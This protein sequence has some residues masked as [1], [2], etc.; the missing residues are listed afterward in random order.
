MLKDQR[1]AEE[2]LRVSELRYRRLFE[3]AQD[4]ILILDAEAGEITDANPFLCELLGYAKT[5]LLGKQLWEIGVF[6]DIIDSK[7]AFQELQLHGYI[8][9]NDLPLQTKNGARIEV[10]FVSN[11]YVVGK[12]SVIQC[13]IRDITDRREIEQAARNRTV[14]LENLTV[15]Q[16]ETRKA[17]LN[18]MEDLEAAKGIIEVE[19]VKD[20]AMLASIGEGLI[21][22]DVNRNVMIINASAEKMFGLR[23]KDVVGHE[24][25]N[26]SLEDEAGHPVPLTK[27]P[28]HLALTTGETVAA[29]YFFVR[30]DKTRFPVAIH[31]TPIKLEGKI[32]GALDIFRD[33]TRETEIDKAKSEFVSLA[34]HQLR[35]PLGII[36]WYLEALEGEDYFKQAPAVV[37][38]YFEE[39]YKSNE[40]VLSLVRDLLSVSRIDQG[41]VKNA[42]QTVDPAQVIVDLVEQMQIVARKK[43]VALRVSM[44]RKPMLSMTLDALR[45]H[46]VLQNLIG[47]GLEYTLAGGSV[48]VRVRHGAGILIIGVHDTGIGISPADQKKIFTKF[49]RS[50]KAIRHNP[51]GSGLGLYVVK[52]YVE[53]WGGTIT[54]ESVEGKGSTFTISLP[55]SVEGEDMKGG[56]EK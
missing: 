9:Y 53:G 26:L 10:E 51:E 20:E 38:S 43:S 41:R 45:F 37:R 31:V 17:M 44:P 36:K 39:I 19:K 25:T 48:E 12:E 18:V 8:R 54:A 2:K 4:G 56:K 11:T 14:E 16:E 42:P 27:R 5:E 23:R 52:A 47:N 6:K 13:N 22:V 30:K 49:F 46:E 34:S 7:K 28:T 55:V 24:I 33:I 32:I 3:A 50:E 21:A 1:Y 40:R 15:S 29:T 35:T